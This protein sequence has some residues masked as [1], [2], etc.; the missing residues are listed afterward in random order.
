VKTIIMI[1][2]F[3]VLSTSIW[4]QGLVVEKTFNNYDDILKYLKVTSLPEI[5]IKTP[6]SIEKRENKIIYTNGTEENI[7]PNIAVSFSPMKKQILKYDR[8]SKILELKDSSGTIKYSNKIDGNIIVGQVSDSG[9]FIS[10]IKGY[11]NPMKRIRDRGDISVEFINN[12]DQTT[13]LLKFEN[14]NINYLRSQIIPEMDCYLLTTNNLLKDG[15]AE[16]RII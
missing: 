8:D 13:K 6:G 1:S 12:R 10:L 16:I 2:S 11:A 5:G 4:G 14:S 9:N 7:L 15:S 3:L